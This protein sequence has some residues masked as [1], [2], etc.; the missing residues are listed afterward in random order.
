M[1]KPAAGPPRR[2][3]ELVAAPAPGARQAIGGPAGHLTQ[4][5]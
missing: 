1:G 5:V 3:S 2:L 4:R